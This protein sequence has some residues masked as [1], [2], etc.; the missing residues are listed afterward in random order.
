MTPLLINKSWSSPVA[1]PIAV[2]GRGRDLPLLGQLGQIEIIAQG[3]RMRPDR[4]YYLFRL[5]PRT[6]SVRSAARVPSQ[7]TY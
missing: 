1:R 6:A 5:V 2:I 4:E 3:P 7:G